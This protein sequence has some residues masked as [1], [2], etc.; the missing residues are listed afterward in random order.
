VP[1]AAPPTKLADSLGP[2]ATPGAFGEVRPGQLALVAGRSGD[3]PSV[4]QTL[5]AVFQGPSRDEFQSQIEDPFYEPLDRLLVRRGHRVLSHVHLTKRALRFGQVNLPIAGVQWLATLP[6]FRT[7]GFATRLLLEADRRIAADGGLVAV[8]R[9]SA[10]HFFAR[11][12]W[13]ICGRHC[14]SRGESRLVQGYLQGEHADKLSRPLSIRLWRHVEMPALMRI[15]KQNTLASFGPLDRTEA[16]W[17]WLIG[18]KA[19]DTLLVAIDGRDRLELAEETAPIVGYAA[20]RQSR[21]VELL[22]A[23]DHPTADFQL[24]ARACAE[25]VERDRRDLFVHAPPEHRVHSLLKAAGGTHCHAESD[26]GEVFM[27]KII[28]P[29]KFLTA[30]APELELRAKGADLQRGVELGLRVG[31]ANWRIVYTHRGIRIRP[32]PMGRSYLSMN[33][34]ELTR[35]VLGHGKVSEI[36]A[37]GRIHA[38]NKSALELADALFPKLPLWRPAWDD[39]PA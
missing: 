6:E 33:S 36:A 17:R 34:A 27:V 18:R 11:S 3:H 28:D 20:L 24:L 8:A 7:Q 23:P 14:V 29:V 4:Y 32:G 1:P 35:L 38:S 19:F 15:Y 30:I 5:L 9:T 26:Q 13:A 2:L 16:Y 12:G 39:L 37:A 22:T 21:V 10:P 25:F 31:A